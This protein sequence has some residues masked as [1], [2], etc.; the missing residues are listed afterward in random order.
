MQNKRV[1]RISEE[2]KKVISGL[3]ITGLKDPR[4]DQMASITS[5]VVSND[6][7][8]AKVYVSTLGDEESR[9]ETIKGLNS[10]KG[11]IKKE[12]AKA[13]D[14]RIMPELEFISDTSIED[15][16]K[17]YEIIDSLNDKDE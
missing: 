10:A 5:V 17:L 11:F 14:L 3:L 8:V 4:V 9:N 12:I 16:M 7:S 13:I 2:I 15:S 1:G 6:G